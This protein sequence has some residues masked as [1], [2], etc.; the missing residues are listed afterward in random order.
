MQSVSTPDKPVESEAVKE[1][2]S[3]STVNVPAVE[4]T[5]DPETESLDDALVRSRELKKS[6]SA[7]T[8]GETTPKK[9]VVY[10]RKSL[11]EIEAEI[12]KNTA[13]FDENTL[14]REDPKKTVMKRK[15]EPSSNIQPAS[16]MRLI[17]LLLI[18]AL[19]MFIGA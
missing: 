14:K 17:R 9:E 16:I 8:T 15:V 2:P 7:S 12:A 11:K 4:N 3:T 1:S 10:T 6:T 5:D 13:K 18:A 19:S